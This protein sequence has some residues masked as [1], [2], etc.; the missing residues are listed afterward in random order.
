MQIVFHSFPFQIL[1]GWRLHD[2]DSYY[3]RRIQFTLE[4]DLRVG[5]VWTASWLVFQSVAGMSRMPRPRS[6]GF[7]KDTVHK[8]HSATHLRHAKVAA[9]TRTDTVRGVY[10]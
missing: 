6:G 9:Y 5:C 1:L 2:I 7:R 8:V 3:W 4:T 10:K